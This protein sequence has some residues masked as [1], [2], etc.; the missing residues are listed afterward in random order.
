ME[1]W[2]FQV[3]HL[4]TRTPHLKI[5]IKITGTFLEELQSE[6]NQEN[7]NPNNNEYISQVDPKFRADSKE[8][9]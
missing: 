7:D 3:G 6:H 8:T 5:A 2:G 9:S 1:V 4:K